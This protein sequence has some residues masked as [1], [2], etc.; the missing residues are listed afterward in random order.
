MTTGSNDVLRFNDIL[1]LFSAKER[2]HT[3]TKIKYANNSTI[4]RACGLWGFR[5]ARQECKYEGPFLWPMEHMIYLPFCGARP[6]P[7][8]MNHFLI[9]V[10]ETKQCYLKNSSATFL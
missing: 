9:P 5:F 1:G 8:Q 2:E 7:V 6:I 4:G 3:Q 10:R